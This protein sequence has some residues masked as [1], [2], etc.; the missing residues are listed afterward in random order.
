MCIY[1]SLDKMLA[2][3]ILKSVIVDIVVLSI[4]NGA[5]P[6]QW[7]KGSIVGGGNREEGSEWDIK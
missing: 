1:A 3:I 2:F 7:R 6:T 4:G 5:P